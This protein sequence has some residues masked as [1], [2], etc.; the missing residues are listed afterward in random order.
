[1]PF[2]SPDPC[3]ARCTCFVSCACV[4]PNLT[5][6]GSFYLQSVDHSAI[7]FALQCL[8]DYVQVKGGFVWNLSV[9]F[10][11]DW[12]VSTNSPVV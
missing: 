7:A 8:V 2:R 3:S 6:V 9:C 11:D 4:D 10:T 1:M 5:L 12:C